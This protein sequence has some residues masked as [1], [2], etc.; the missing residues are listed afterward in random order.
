[1]SLYQKYR[2]KTL[3]G[4]RGNRELVKTLEAM[5]SNLETCPHS[6]LLTGPTGCGKTTIARI[7]GKN[8]GAT[9]NSIHEINSA[10]FRGI[11][12]VRDIRRSIQ[13]LPIEG[14]S[15]VYII[16]EAHKMT[17]DAQNGILKILEDTPNH[18]FFI[19]CTT[20]PQKLINT[21]KGRCSTFQVNPLNDVQMSKLLTRIATKEGE[22]LDKK[23]LNQIIT[24]SQGFPRNAI[25]ILEQVLNAPEEDRLK[26][27]KRTA[28]EE[29]EVVELCR[30][31]SKR[32][33]WKKV[34][35]IL[36]RLKNQGTDPE[37]IRRMV[38]GYCQA[39]L[40]KADNEGMGAIMEEFIDPFYDTGFPGLTY[41]CYAVIKS[42]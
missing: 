3:K 30:A 5:L 24:D 18:V 31:L 25:Q 8:V 41:A 29:S 34:S 14:D 20:D 12:T 26:I 27:A 42:S 37:N 4:V 13:L 38:L 11:E 1:M 33:S 21:I 9:S 19:L 32:E 6:F 17:N 35:G 36:S 7:I 16:D 23:V 2:P 15:T 28:E 40:L 39:V 22:E 10:D